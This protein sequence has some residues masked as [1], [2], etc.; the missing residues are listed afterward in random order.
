MLKRLIYELK[1]LI[2]RWKWTSSARVVPLSPAKLGDE[3]FYAITALRLSRM[4][5]WRAGYADCVA[6]L[7]DTYSLLFSIGIRA[8]ERKHRSKSQQPEV[9]TQ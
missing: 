2:P 1:K 6:V 8:R 3:F 4:E 9:P 7:D 5:L